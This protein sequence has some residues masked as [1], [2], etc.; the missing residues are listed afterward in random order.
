[1]RTI[2][3]VLHG[4]VLGKARPRFTRQGGTYTPHA[5]REYEDAVRHAYVAAGGVML[6]GPI[7]IDLEA[8]SGIQKTAT[9]KQQTDRLMGNELSLR[10]PDI[11]NIEKIVL[12]ALNGVAYQD[13]RNVVS[14][15]K[16]KG[17][18]E[19]TPKILVR[20]REI[21]PSEMMSIHSFMWGND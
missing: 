7:H 4:K 11:D 8:V 6:E 21:E 19:D 5:T 18:Y 17:R 2:E 16:I 20:V 10:K 3:F 14:V 9:K 13:D 12:D 1:M 15:R